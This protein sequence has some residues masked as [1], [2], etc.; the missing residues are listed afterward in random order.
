MDLNEYITT[1]HSYKAEI[2]A[3][4]SLQHQESNNASF[5]NIDINIM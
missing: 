5:I 4:L 3:L 2:R 1:I